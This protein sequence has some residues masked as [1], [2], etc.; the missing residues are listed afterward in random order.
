MTA[1][2][3]VNHFVGISTLPI[4]HL[5]AIYTVPQL[6]SP[7]EVNATTGTPCLTNGTR[8]T[9]LPVIET[10]FINHFEALASLSHAKCTTPPHPPI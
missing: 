1:S 5:L 3:P 9:C 4:N 8:V 2:V 7:I 6:F 10:H